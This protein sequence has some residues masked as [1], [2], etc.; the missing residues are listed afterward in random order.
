[1]RRKGFTL[2][3]LIIVII[4]IGILASISVPI[5][6][7]NVSRARQSEAVTALGTLRTAARMYTSARGRA[8][9]ILNDLLLP[10]GYMARTDLGGNYYINSGYMVFGNLIY[11]YNR[12]GQFS[13]YMN[14]RSGY[15]YINNNLP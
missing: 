3:E 13:C 8:P 12:S 14:W 1:M 7:R 2:I 6:R 11:A 5:M 9:T 4:I 10:N 15:L